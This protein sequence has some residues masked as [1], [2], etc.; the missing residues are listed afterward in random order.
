MPQISI[1]E[2]YAVMYAAGLRFYYGYEE[3]DHGLWCF[4]V[5]QDEHEIFR[6]PHDKLG[7]KDMFE[8]TECLL[9]G[10]AMW[11]EHTKKAVD[12]KG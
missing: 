10:I 4:T 2:D 12:N 3:Q 6:L 5:T 11:M 7:C 9:H 1:A 8:T